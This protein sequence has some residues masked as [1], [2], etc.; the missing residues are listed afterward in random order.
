V[1]PCGIVTSHLALR[2][3]SLLWHHFFHQNSAGALYPIASPWLALIIYPEALLAMDNKSSQALIPDSLRSPG[4]PDSP[5]G[6]PK[7]GSDTRYVP[8]AHQAGGGIYNR[9]SNMEATYPS[10]NFQS[11]A[12]SSLA[13][14][15]PFKSMEQVKSFHAMKQNDAVRTPKTPLSAS[16]AHSLLRRSSNTE[17]A[18]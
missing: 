4:M 6:Q 11:P 7:A 18:S 16:P 2:P 1:S 3:F 17:S 9:V 8:L 15:G 14:P 12:L 13:S 10:P 5:Y